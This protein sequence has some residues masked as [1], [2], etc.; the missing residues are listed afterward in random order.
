M[1]LVAIDLF[2]LTIVHGPLTIT[3]LKLNKIIHLFLQLYLL[4]PNI[5]YLSKALKYKY[6]TIL[7]L[8]LAGCSTEKNT[9]TTRTYHNLTSHFNIYFNGI[10]SIKKGVLKAEDSKV[11]NYSQILPLFFYTDKSISQSVTPEMD[12]AAKKATKVI[13]IHSITV[14]PEMKKGIQTPKQKEFY[15]QK[16]FNNWMDENYLMLGISYV[17]KNEYNL[18]IETFKH[19]ISDFPH[20]PSKYAALIWLSRCYNEINELK[21][22][23]KIFLLLE[24]D[25]KMPEK[26]YEDFY[27]S[28]CDYY[29][30]QK[31]Y[32][33]AAPLLEK[34]LENCRRKKYRIRYTYILAQ[35]YQENGN[36][37]KAADNYK[38]VIKMN[39]PYEMT[40]N[41]KI[42]LAGSFDVSKGEGKEIR[43]LLRKMLKD[44]K[45][46][47]FQDQIYYALGKISLKENKTDEAIELFRESS[48]KSTKNLN[49]KGL[50]YL[51]LA[52]IYY[53]MQEYTFAQAYYDSTLQN[54]NSEFEN[55]SNISLKAGSL[56]KLVK[57]LMV[58]N[59][60][61]SLQTLSKMTDSDRFAAIDKLIAAVV[62]KEQDE[63]KKK[64]EELM[65]TQFGLLNQ[66]IDNSNRSGE[67]ATGKWYFYN[68]AA[69]SFGQPEFRMKWG[70]RK[71]EDNWRRNNKQTVEVFEPAET[72]ELKDSAAGTENK[73]LVDNK[74]REFYLKDIP[75]T[76]EDLAKSHEMLKEALYNA[77]V[78][79]LEDLMDTDK[80]IESFE[81]LVKRYPDDKFAL[82]SYYAMY[83][84]FNK[85]GD[86]AEARKN[87]NLI[88]S[89]FPESPTALMLSNPD[90]VKQI[91][92]KENAVHNSYIET[93]NL[94][95]S[96]DYTGV[97]TKVDLAR[98]NYPGDH[99]LP[100]FELLRALSLGHLQGREKLKQE[101]DTLV[102]YYPEHEAGIYAKELIEYIY[103]QTPEIKIAD[104]RQAAEEIYKFDSAEIHYFLL[105]IPKKDDVNQINF[106]MINF[107][108]D[109]FDNL[110]LGIT[111][112]ELGDTTIIKVGSFSDAGNA[113]I[114][115]DSFLKHPEILKW[116]DPGIISG[117]LIS[118]SNLIRLVEDKDIVKY[119]LYYENHY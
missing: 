51:T 43:V 113:L 61:D 13:T 82:L 3:F 49:Q 34:A 115:R 68:P 50:T 92:D 102:R 23:E 62:Q 87:M 119:N 31:N 6:I 106:N 74:S 41:A 40:F 97:L 53:N 38:K 45:N 90:Y 8:V 19:I 109:N 83:D 46:N 95:N 114:Y 35:I 44:E 24:A 110:N 108:L 118:E 26:M 96:G 105:A 21:E 69:K 12:Q 22:S 39:P 72:K 17:Y 14:K 37:E 47:E 73:V 94:F 4:L 91:Q 15:N 48:G 56:T 103:S 76:D 89:K 78:I 60:Q 88:I 18:A 64:Q 36:M 5:N 1:W 85:K 71:L 65:D 66:G 57:N 79:Y 101:L 84:I 10:E 75:F 52:D 80:A 100:R 20:T 58:F 42:N 77:G 32:E 98:N 29:L 30:K 25:E 54:I 99:L 2:Y 70:N 107:N 59:L 104:T 116:F 117:F 86:D 7:F 16:E 55:Y 93:Y 9:T 33:K 27:T 63:A 28:Y 111:R 112:L 81:E 11:D 67:S